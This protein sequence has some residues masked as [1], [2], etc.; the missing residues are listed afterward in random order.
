MIKLVKYFNNPFTEQP[1][2]RLAFTLD[3]IFKLFRAAD[4]SFKSHNQRF[5][6]EWPE[7]SPLRFLSPF[8][9]SIEIYI[10]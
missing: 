2:I 4:T 3:L 7:F 6:A 8:E 9:N 1:A 10:P 5:F